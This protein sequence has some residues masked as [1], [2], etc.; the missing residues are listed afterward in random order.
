MSLL[1]DKVTTRLS[2]DHDALSSISVC[3]IVKNE[4]YQLN[5]L[6]T[7]LDDAIEEVIV[8][9]TGSTDDTVS[10]ASQ[11]KNV[12]VYHFPWCNDF[13]KARNESIKYA[14]KDYILW[15]D[16]DDMIDKQDIIKLKFHLH[17]YPGKAVYL[18]LQDIQAGNI[19][20]SLQLRIFPNVPGVE[21]VGR[22]HEQVTFS[23]DKLGILTTAA[24]IVVQH[25]GYDSAET[26]IRK[27]KRNLYI[28]LE[29]LRSEPNNYLVNLN[30]GKCFV[31]I[32]KFSEAEPY[33][34]RAI[35]VLETTKTIG[36][37]DNFFLAYVTKVTILSVN[38]KTD[39][40]VKLLESKRSDFAGL[41]IYNYTMGEM[42]FRTKNY[43]KAYKDLL[44]LKN[45][46]DFGIIPFN[47]QALKPLW[48]FFLTS[49]IHLG[50]KENI[51]FC[52]R[53][54][55]EDKEFTIPW[56]IKET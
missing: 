23:L 10:I 41:T 45:N 16:A 47:K 6:L 40:A 50:D 51:E 13:A 25:Y 2:F 1:E 34:D 38:G 17:N 9:D 12:K 30:I 31:G 22:V 52:I 36:S 26:V 33:I 49:C 15:L 3:M 7:A 21:F 55:T 18:T 39:E 19:F 35:E 20:S 37:K 27:L 5:N 56:E 48:I 28:L 29:E 32:E 42:Y 53:T 8:V 44:S 54:L 43:K 24:P 14:T 46:S 4:A 11:H